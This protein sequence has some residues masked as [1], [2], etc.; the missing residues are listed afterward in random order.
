MKT[1]MVLKHNK[2][3]NVFAH[4]FFLFF[5]AQILSPSVAN[6]TIYIE[7]IVAFLNPYFWQWLS[8]SKPCMQH[9]ISLL[10]LLFI[11]V[12]GKVD[13]A[14]KLSVIFFDVLYLFYLYEKKLWKLDLY[15]CISILFAIFQFIFLFTNPVMA[16]AI[17]PTNIS[18]MIWGGYGTATYTNFYTIFEDGIPHV[19]GLSRE[20]GFM[21]SFLLTVL[22]FHYI[23]KDK[24]C[25]L[26]KIL[27]LMGY[28]F[29]FSK[30]SFLILCVY[31]LKKAE[32]VFNFIPVWAV[33]AVWTFGMICFWD[34]NVDFLMEPSNVTFLHRFGAYINIESMDWK[35][36][37]FGT[38]T[39]SHIGTVSAT[40]TAISGFNF[41]AGFG[42]WLISNGLLVAAAYV[43]LLYCL[44]I[45]SIGTVL[46]LLFTLNVQV[47]T[48]QNF[49]VFA[50]F[51]IFKYYTCK[52]RFRTLRQAIN[53]RR[54]AER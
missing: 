18:Q 36:F 20:A 46:L 25:S 13:T 35:G 49:V 3:E 27:F 19:S 40:S 28:I 50:Y 24:L 33:I 15:L 45:S 26:K 47:D 11:A 39:I 37:L 14:V 23:K 32:N 52:G 9:M 2:I 43:L 42:G 48:N 1:K 5:V 21:A 10:L 6:R 41:F 30:M 51:L 31:L 4:L 53:R 8:R 16:H 17:G 38:E 44:D 34:A 12:C 7:T 29:T 22:F 54:L